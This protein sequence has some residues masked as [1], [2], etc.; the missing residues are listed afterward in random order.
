MSLSAGSTVWIWI[1]QPV[2]DTNLAR[3]QGD[4]PFTAH[5]V[6]VYEPVLREF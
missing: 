4:V 3:Y 2:I 6:D 5:L 1:D